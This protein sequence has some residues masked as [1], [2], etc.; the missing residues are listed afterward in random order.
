MSGRIMVFCMEE[1]FL[2][3]NKVSVAI[4]GHWVDDWWIPKTWNL[5][6]G[7]ENP[8]GLEPTKRPSATFAT[9]L[10]CA[11]TVV[12]SSA[13]CVYERNYVCSVFAVRFIPLTKFV[14]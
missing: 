2:P 11:Y 13:A 3:E 5:S 12:L 4:S 7:H 8:V 9:L 1:Y 6:L 14:D 10:S